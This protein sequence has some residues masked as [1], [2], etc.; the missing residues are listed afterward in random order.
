GEAGVGKTSLVRYLCG[1]IGHG[2][3]GY[4]S[5]RNSI[6]HRRGWLAGKVLDHMYGQL[7]NRQRATLEGYVTSTVGAEW[8]PLLAGL[9]DLSGEDNEWTKGLSGELRLQKTR[10]LFARLVESLLVDAQALVIDDCESIDEYSLALLLSLAESSPDLPLLILLICRQSDTLD[11]QDALDDSVEVEPPSDSEWSEFFTARFSDGKREEEFCSRLLR[12]SGGNPHIVTGFIGRCVQERLLEPSPL[13][14]KWSLVSSDFAI[15]PPGSLRDAHLSH[16]DRLPEPDRRLLKVVAVSYGPASAQLLADVSN[17]DG[18]E[19]GRRLKA[20]SGSHLLSMTEDGVAYEYMSESMRE[21]VYSC[22]P[23]ERLVELHALYARELR[24]TGRNERA[25]ALAYHYERAGVP[26]E[27]FHFALLAAGESSQVHALNEAARFLRQCRSNLLKN[28]PVTLGLDGVFKFHRSYASSLILEGKYNEAYPVFRE[29]RR[30]GKRHNRE[31]ECVIAA[32]ETS[33]TLWRQSRYQ[34]SR[35]IVSRL[36]ASKAFDRNQAEF[37]AA[38][39]VMSDLERRAGNFAG[40]REWCEK[41]IKRVRKER[42]GV[43]LANGHNKLGLALWGAGLLEQAARSFRASLRYGK[44]RNDNYAQARTLNNLGIIKHA[45]G[46][47]VD[48]EELLAEALQSF[49]KI[50][51]IR[52]E[53]YASGNLANVSRILGKFQRSRALF[54]QADLIFQKVGDSHA[55]H[56]TVGNIGDIDLIEG[57]W[58][59]AEEK[60]GRVSKFATSVGDRELNAECRV[61]FGELAFFTDDMELAEKRYLDAIR[62][63]QEIGSKEWRLRASIGLARLYIG[64]RRESEAI[65]LIGNISSTA[66]ETRSV[67]SQNEAAFL[68]GEYSRIANRPEE[69]TGKFQSAMKYA[70]ANSVFELALKSAVRLY[71]VDS[72]GSEKQFALLSGV[73]DKFISQNSLRQWKTI[74]ASGYL[75]YFSDGLNRALREGGREEWLATTHTV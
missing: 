59:R 40:A 12:V 31:R 10:R 21:A 16:F 60:F 62:E 39:S 37:A 68:S 46:K 71:E 30:L 61:R 57:S 67:I 53:S 45:L 63:A 34:R 23:R 18:G 17:D 2:R 58:D 54:E 69:A 36:L 47:Y 28:D 1:H 48:S 11:G 44:G 24:E 14:G 49:K 35:L 33:R 55:H 20:L 15:E 13:T 65:E 19:I 22:I 73:I 64:E 8:S 5:G 26:R 70:V 38:C 42:D 4:F 51:D 3:C 32:L 25:D 72:E 41:S 43:E 7:E 27:S 52:K 9:F 74:A 6:L 66:M 75:S 56:Y 50:G 29:W